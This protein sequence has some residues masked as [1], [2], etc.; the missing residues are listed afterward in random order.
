M[1][2]RSQ[3]ARVYREALRDTAEA[4]TYLKGRGLSG[5]IAAE[6]GI[7]FAPVGWDTLLKALGGDDPGRQ[8]LSA[9]GLIIRRDDGRYYDR[10][11]DRIMFPI[12]DSRGRIIAF[13]GRVLGTDEPKYLN[14]PETPLFHKGRELYGLYAARQAVRDIQRLLVV[15]GYMDVVALHQHG[16]R[17]EIGRAHV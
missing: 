12:R 10:F 1:L 17:Y 8:S 3:A 11:R 16:L 6:F 2:F 15:E 4:V 7:G 14:S 9:A 13:G 5:E